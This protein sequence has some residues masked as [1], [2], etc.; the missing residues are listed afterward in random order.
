MMAVGWKKLGS[1]LGATLVVVACSSDENGVLTADGSIIDVSAAG[2][3][4][5]AGSAGSESDASA[6]TE[7]GGGGSSSDAA[8]TSDAP[9]DVS[10]FDV[11]AEA[12]ICN[13]LVNS[14]MVVTPTLGAGMAAALTGG[15]IVDGIYEET[16]IEQFGGDG[17]LPP[18][19]QSTINISAGTLTEVVKVGAVE[20]RFFSTYSVM[21]MT[22]TIV[23]TCD[24]TFKFTG[25]FMAAYQAS[26]TTFIY[27]FA[28]NGGTLVKTYTKK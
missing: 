6:A 3:A 14:A 7:S 8:T 22:I 28:N 25:S 11:N 1:V 21:M 18:A 17:G 16:K 2:S 24:S 13:A 12:G 9:K 5:T 23:T 27:S 10:A 15:T 26:P 19:E 20:T 4:G